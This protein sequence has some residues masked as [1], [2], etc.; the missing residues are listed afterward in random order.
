MK[1][2]MQE[3]QILVKAGYSATSAVTQISW[4]KIGFQA[5]NASYSTLIGYCW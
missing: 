1:Q 5:T 2:Q 4:V 3:T